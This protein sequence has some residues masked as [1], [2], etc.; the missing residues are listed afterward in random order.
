MIATFLIVVVLLWNPCDV[1]W[2]DFFKECHFPLFCSIIWIVAVLVDANLSA[3]IV[4]LIRE[5]ILN[6]RPDDFVDIH[7]LMAIVGIIGLIGFKFFPKYLKM[8]SIK[9]NSYTWKDIVCILI[10]LSFISMT[11]IVIFADRIKM[12]R[13][14]ESWSTKYFLI[15]SVIQMPFYVFSWIFLYMHAEKKEKEKEN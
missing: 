15:F 9:D 14:P 11:T 3:C 10:T 2:Y 4:G 12:T 7:L 1:T 13:E 5:Y 6:T 8:A